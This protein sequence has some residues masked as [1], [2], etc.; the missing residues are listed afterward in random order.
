MRR[1]GNLKDVNDVQEM[2]RIVKQQKN[3]QVDVRDLLHSQGGRRKLNWKI[4]NQEAT[5][6][7]MNER[8]SDGYVS[9]GNAETA[10]QTNSRMPSGLI[11]DR[12]RSRTN[13]RMKA[14]S[15]RGTFNTSQSVPRMGYNK[16]ASDGT[17]AE[18]ITI[19]TD[20][21]RMVKV[22]QLMQG[23]PGRYNW[24]DRNLSTANVMHATQQ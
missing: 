22:S 21:P 17:T 23:N 11:G 18:P 13:R 7:S 20:M 9:T 6:L 24:P 1:T 15:A 16:R 2:F 12:S 14:V 5:H 4:L 3:G 19:S 10:A 8:Q